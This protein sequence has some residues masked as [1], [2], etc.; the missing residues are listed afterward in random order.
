MPTVMISPA[1][2]RY[3]C[4]APDGT[5]TGWNPGRKDRFEGGQ[6]NLQGSFIPFAATRAERLATGDTRPSIEERYPN[7]DAYVGG[8]PSGCGAVGGAAVSAVR[9]C[10]DT[11]RPGDGKS[12]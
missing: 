9:R 11:D 5:Y 4:R 7:K 12:A 10:R 1:S 6:C 8:D 2:G 3:F